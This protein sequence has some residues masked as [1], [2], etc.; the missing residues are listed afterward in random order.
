MRFRFIDAERANYPVSILCRCLRVSRAGYYAWRRRP[1]S[2]RSIENAELRVAIKA[3]HK[4][5]GGTYGSPRIHEDLQEEGRR[6]SRKRVA[7]LMSAE[8]IQGRHKRRF[9]TTTDSNHERPVAANLLMRDFDVPSPNL[10]WAT[11]ITYLRTRD[12]W[13][14]LAVILDLFSRRVVGYAISDRIDTQLVL[15]ALDR[16][17]TRR[18]GARDVIIHSDR[19][20]QYASGDFRQALGDSK[21]IPSMSRRGNCWDNAVVESF[22]GTLKIELFLDEPLHGAA[23]TEAMV[24]DYIDGFYNP[25]RRHSS[26]GQI[27]PIEY[28]LRHAAPGRGGSAPAPRDGGIKLHGQEGPAQAA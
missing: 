4:A 17:V 11:D 5:S 28:E 10:A 15:Q 26:I 20:S 25:V 14:Y 16:A 9:R 12:G 3:A 13:L 24:V 19:G 8:G 23:I 2:W 21:L 27:S 7:A 18:P 6:V 22:F 1:P